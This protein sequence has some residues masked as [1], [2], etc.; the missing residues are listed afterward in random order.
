MDQQNNIFDRK[1][2]YRME[3]CGQSN[4]KDL[5]AYNI[6]CYALRRLEEEKQPTLILVYG[7]TIDIPGLQTPVKFLTDF[8]TKRFRHG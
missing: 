6:W 7:P 1:E 5:Q 3:V 4:R 8:I 2:L